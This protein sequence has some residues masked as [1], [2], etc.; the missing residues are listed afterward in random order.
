MTTMAARVRLAWLLPIGVAQVAVWQ[1]GALAVLA[2]AFP[3]DALAIV[4]MALAAAA[5]AMTS[6]RIGGRCGYEW[7]A[8]YVR[9]LLRRSSWAGE[10]PVRALEPR[11]HIH[12]YVDRANNRFGIASIDQDANHSVTVRLAPSAQP[13]PATLISVLRNVFDRT[14]SALSG[15]QL[16]V[17]TVPAPDPLSVYWLALRYR[18]DDAPWAAL[19]R[20]GGQDGRHKAVA[21]AALRLV[22]ELADAGYASSVLDT[23][24]LHNELMAAV[25]A[26]SDAVHGSGPPSYRAE[27]NWR[28][29]SVGKLRQACFVPR[30]AQD[31]V[32]LM[33]RYVPDAAFTCTSYTLH[34][35]A[36]GSVREVAAV[37]VGLPKD[38]PAPQEAATALGGHLQPAHGRHGRHV[39]T[40]L[41]LALP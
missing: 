29:W 37:R 4:V 16:V 19:A 34:R 36:Y 3:I 14:D 24:D 41:P 27:E 25:G 28:S 33:G 18:H 30:S 20:G 31:A 9:Y 7:L 5:V 40:T 15:A 10:T 1:L 21:S 35:T 22:S 38:G 12:T 2:T 23:P 6:I 32:A 8:T 11:L 17:W 26:D 39:L 13:A